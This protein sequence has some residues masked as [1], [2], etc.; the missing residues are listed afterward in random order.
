M[1]HVVVTFESGF[2]GS[3]SADTNTGMKPIRIERW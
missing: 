1:G 2:R 3:L